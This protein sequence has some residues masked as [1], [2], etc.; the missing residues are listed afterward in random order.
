MCVQC[1]LLFLGFSWS[2]PTGMTGCPHHVEV[3][4]FQ[5][6][7][8]YAGVVCNVKCMDFTHVLCLFGRS[9]GSCFTRAGIITTSL[10]G[11]NCDFCRFWDLLWYFYFA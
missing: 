5:L 9:C 2:F 8:P 4:F 10:S 3:V 6:L 1:C 11:R 7:C